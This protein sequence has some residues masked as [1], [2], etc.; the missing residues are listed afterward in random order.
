M[1]K[2]S[3]KKRKAGKKKKITARI[4]RFLDFYIK[5][6]NATQSYSDAGFNGKWPGESARDLLKKPHVLE[7]L[8]KRRAKI[9]EEIGVTPAD[10]IREHARIA[11][12][13]SKDFFEWAEQEV[14]LIPNS[15]VFKKVSRILIKPP[16][17]ITYEKAAAI[18]G[19]KETAQ[20]GLE[21]KFHD[22][23]KSLDFLG[24]YFGISNKA[25][26]DKARQIKKAED[27]QP[28]PDPTEG[29]DE[30]SIDK[31]LKELEG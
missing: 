10:V 6:D 30:E 9:A 29:M 19:I 24:S 27:Q 22:K 23:Q 16:S 17:D 4:S 26:V 18:S 28:N 7:E 11:F 3:R 2:T 31:A 1:P 14:E 8:E 12:A 25:Q 21:F 5:T 13:N 15:G 20:G